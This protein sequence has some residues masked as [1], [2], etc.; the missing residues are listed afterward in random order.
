MASTSVPE[1]RH[2]SPL[3][4]WARLESTTGCMPAWYIEL[5]AETLML[6]TRKVYGSPGRV[7]E[8]EK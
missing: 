5:L 3:S 6:L 1:R 2:P 7:F 4:S 8:T